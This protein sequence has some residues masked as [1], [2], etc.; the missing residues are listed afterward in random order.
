MARSAAGLATA[1]RATSGNLLASLSH[2]TQ[3]ACRAGS[4]KSL[5]IGRTNGIRRVFVLEHGIPQ[6]FQNFLGIFGKRRDLDDWFSAICNDQWFTG[7]F[8]LPEILE[9]ACLESRFGYSV[10]T[11]LHDS[12][13]INMVTYLSIALFLQAA[14][15]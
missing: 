1:L 5:P 12:G 14:A 11:M 2:Q 15:L 4:T 7:L 6:F 9:H 3:P 8:D 13:Q 10:F